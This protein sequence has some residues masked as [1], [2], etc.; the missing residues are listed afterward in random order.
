MDYRNG[1]PKYV[2]EDGKYIISTYDL[3]RELRSEVYNSF[4]EDV[5]RSERT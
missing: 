3:E 2:L 4:P 5:E 1:K